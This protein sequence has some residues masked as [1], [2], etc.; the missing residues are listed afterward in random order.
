MKC[1]CGVCHVHAF[2]AF[3][4][5]LQIRKGLLRRHSTQ[6]TNAYKRRRTALFSGII[7][8]L[9]SRPVER[10]SFGSWKQWNTLDNWCDHNRTTTIAKPGSRQ[11]WHF[12]VQVL[13]QL[14]CCNSSLLH[15][16]H[17]MP[18]C[19]SSNVHYAL[20]GLV[21]SMMLTPPHCF[22]YFTTTQTRHD[23]R[24]AIFCLPCPE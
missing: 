23:S 16:F 3:G 20:I 17:S 24:V 22:A 7:V 5:G 21:R 12:W 19:Y 18:S 1:R 13:R 9:D 8:N 11:W 4:E 14:R 15:E 6:L 2:L 10:R